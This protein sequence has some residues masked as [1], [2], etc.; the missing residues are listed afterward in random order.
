MKKNVIKLVLGA[1][2]SLAG[3]NGYDFAIENYGET[4]IVLL[5]G[6]TYETKDIV[7]SPTKAFKTRDLEGIEGIVWHY[8]AWNTQDIQKVADWH[9]NG[10]HWAGIGYHG[11]IKKDGTYLVLNSLE[12]LSYHS[13]GSNTKYIGIVFMTD[14]E[15]TD[16]QLKT[17]KYIQEAL[18]Y[19]LPIKKVVGHRDVRATECPGDEAY[20]QL[21][22]LGF[23][24]DA[25]KQ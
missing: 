7:K 12:T 2:L 23:F 8:S 19:V 15:L 14:G 24:F 4:E 21:N 18:C 10:N 5:D 6:T 22:E 25:T 20:N 13:K 1:A 11:A 17:A 16:N 9:V 3:Y